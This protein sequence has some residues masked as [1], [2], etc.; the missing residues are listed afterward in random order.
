MGICDC[1]A[2]SLTAGSSDGSF[3]RASSLVFTPIGIAFAA[4]DT[5]PIF[6]AIERWKE[7]LAFSDGTFAAPLEE[8]AALI[9]ESDAVDAIFQTV[10][11]TSAGIRAK[12]DFAFSVNHVTNHLKSEI[13]DEPL[14]TFLDTLYESARMMAREA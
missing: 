4:T 5:D 1:C 6:P 12:I 10:P 7:A 8:E 9:K 14:R 2:R 13:S 3:S 11:T